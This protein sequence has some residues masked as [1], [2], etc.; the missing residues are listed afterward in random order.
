M[1]KFEVNEAL[2][3][4]SYFICD[5]ALSKLYLKSDKENPWFVLVP[6]KPDLVE[7]MELNGEDQGLLMEEVTIVS[8]FLKLYYHP[9]KINIG[10]LGNIVR[11][12]HFHVIARFQED[13]AWPAPIWGS[14]PELVMSEIEL[15]NIKSNFLDFIN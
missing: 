9:Y 14:A 11:Q 5:L 13:R 15:E 10:S 2:L 8:E 1:A 7:L 3:T 6:R 12:L 4:D